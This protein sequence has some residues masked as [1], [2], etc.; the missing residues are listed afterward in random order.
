MIGII[1]YGMGNIGSVAKAF[2]Y[3]GIKAK[4]GESPG[5]LRGT[6]AIVLPGV[7]AFRDAM[8]NLRERGFIEFLQEEV[9]EKKKPYLGICLGLQ[10]IFEISEE[11]GETEGFGWIPGRVVRFELPD[12]YKIPHMG[13]NQIWLKGEHPVFD[14][15]E[16]GNYFYFVHS[17]Y[18]K[19][20]V[21]DFTFATTDYGVDFT[22]VVIKENIIAVQFHPEKSGRLG[23]RIL[24]NFF[25]WSLE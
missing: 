17:F 8:K 24:N 3:L 10:L 15:I 22:S 13:W 19:P 4:V 2:D 12:E 25:R 6:H 21:D 23:L 9:I 7:G 20:S 11:F 18:A 14:R 16:S 5:D 1:D